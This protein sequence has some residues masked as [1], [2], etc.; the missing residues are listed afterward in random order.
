[1]EVLTIIIHNVNL[2]LLM[3]ILF[4]LPPALGLPT[5]STQEWCSFFSVPQKKKFLAF[6]TQWNLPLKSNVPS[7]GLENISLIS[8]TNVFFVL[9]LTQQSL[10]W[11]LR[12]LLSN[13]TFDLEFFGEPRPIN[14]T[15]VRE[16][17]LQTANCMI[18]YPF[19][20]FNCN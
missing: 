8:V 13:R 12:L 11:Q 3:E 6:S 7:G 1:M 14:I 20:I 9:K 16:K 15:N 18:N 19:R 4:L 10:I 5:L 17:I 2:I